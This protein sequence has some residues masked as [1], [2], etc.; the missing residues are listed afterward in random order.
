M[1]NDTV[2]EAEANYFAVCL[3]M[4]E[5]FLRK[6]IAKLGISHFDIIEDSRLQDLADRYQV[7]LQMMIMRL[8]GLGLLKI[9]A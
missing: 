5:E 1:D 4:P 8:A 9:G 2:Q 6:D 7:T 3:L